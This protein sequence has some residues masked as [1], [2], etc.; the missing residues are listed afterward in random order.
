MF[1]VQKKMK[2]DGDSEISTTSL[3]ASLMCPVSSTVATFLWLDPGIAVGIPA[4]PH[5][6]HGD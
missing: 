5:Y 4:R 6:F 2:V 3:R 1:S